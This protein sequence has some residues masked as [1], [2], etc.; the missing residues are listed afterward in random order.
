MDTQKVLKRMVFWA[1]QY[2]DARFPTMPQEMEIFL[3]MLAALAEAT[4]EA[5]PL[6]SLPQSQMGLL[7]FIHYQ[8]YPCCDRVTVPVG[9]VLLDERVAGDEVAGYGSGFHPSID[10]SYTSTSSSSSSTC[11]SRQTHAH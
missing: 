9:L 4:A 6:M 10:S 7:S 2:M 8:T 11:L 5:Q 1:G 3:P